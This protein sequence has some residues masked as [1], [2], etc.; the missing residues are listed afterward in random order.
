MKLKI[1]FLAFII[2]VS[3][4]FPPVVNA[5]RYVPVPPVLNN[6]IWYMDMDSLWI[7]RGL[8]NE[9]DA[10]AF[11]IKNVGPNMEYHAWVRL[12]RDGTY[13]LNNIRLYA[14]NKLVHKRDTMTDRIPVQKI[15]QL[16]TIWKDFYQK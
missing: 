9:V 5:T 15:P 12:N 2:S 3:A 13:N 10:I 4:L 6:E 1:I 14:Y 8:N 11:Y 16:Y 7:S